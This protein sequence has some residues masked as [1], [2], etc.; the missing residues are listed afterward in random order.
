VEGDVENGGGIDYGVD[1]CEGVVGWEEL[2][3]VVDM[4]GRRGEPWCL[5]LLTVLWTSLGYSKLW[6]TMIVWW[7]RGDE[8]ECILL[9]LFL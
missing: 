7:V 8:R 1:G 5:Y 9:I 6:R 2:V 4:E 3:G